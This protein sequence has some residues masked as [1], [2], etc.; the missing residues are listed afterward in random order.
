MNIPNI[1]DTA[2]A[3]AD[4]AALAQWERDGRMD[5]G[6]CGGA[7]LQLDGRSAV[8]KEALARKWAYKSGSEVFVM[9]RVPDGIRTQH[10]TVFENHLRA[11]RDSLIEQGHAKA[12]AKFW[13]YI[14]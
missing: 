3:A 4:A 14:D 9:I 11:F 5:C 8:A 6:S 7:M 13:T 2:R 12:I 10:A 1:L